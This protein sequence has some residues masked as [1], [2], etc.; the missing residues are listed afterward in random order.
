[1]LDQVADQRITSHMPGK[2]TRIQELLAID[3]PGNKR[4]IQNFQG[5]STLLSGSFELPQQ[6]SL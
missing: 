2:N 1:M 4:R 5:D 6:V 3:M